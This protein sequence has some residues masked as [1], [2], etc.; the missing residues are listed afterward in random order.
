MAQS[1]LSRDLPFVIPR[2]SKD[3]SYLPA[4]TFYILL[5]CY[6]LP[7]FSSIPVSCQTRI[8][9]PLKSALTS[10][11][12]QTDMSPRKIEINPYSPLA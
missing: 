10:G 12:P 4:C 3:F 7:W 11:I 9:D 1:Y 6:M 2:P 8:R 5:V